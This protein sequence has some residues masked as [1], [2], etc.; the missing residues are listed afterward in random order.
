ML[1]PGET[2]WLSDR[3]SDYLFVIVAHA[4]AHSV[5]N[6][7]AFYYSHHPTHRKTTGRVTPTTVITGSVVI[8]VVNVVVGVAKHKLSRSRYG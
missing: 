5:P 6:I 2:L 7:W 8:I 3:A 4:T 1:Q